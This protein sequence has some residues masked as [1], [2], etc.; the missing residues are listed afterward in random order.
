MAMSILSDSVLVESRAARDHELGGMSHDRA[1]AILAKVKSLYFSL[2]KGTG[3]ATTEQVADFY[4]VP[5]ANIRKAIERHRAE[6]ES[7]GLQVLSSKALKQVSDL[8]SLT[9]TAPKIT[10][11]TPRSTLR[12]GMTME[13][14]PIAKAVRTSLL[15]AVEAIPAAIEKVRE[16]ELQL[17]IAQAQREAAADQAET[18]RTQERLMVASQL[19]GSINPDLPLLILRPDVKVIERTVPV[20]TTVLVDQHNRA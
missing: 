3:V 6:V 9:S 4:E 13:D 5:A 17:A 16:L 10:V 12:L 8:V 1:Q 18:A 2:W 7:D 14:S 20:E 15:D 19:L 11:H